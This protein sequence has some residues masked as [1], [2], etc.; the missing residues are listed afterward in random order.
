MKRCRK[1]KNPDSL[2][3]AAIQFML[4]HLQ[5][6][7]SCSQNNNTLL[8][9]IERRCHLGC[10]KDLG[11][12]SFNIGTSMDVLFAQNLLTYNEV[13]DIIVADS[14]TKKKLLDDKLATLSTSKHL[15]YLCTIS[16]CFVYSPASANSDQSSHQEDTVPSLNQTLN[17]SEQIYSRTWAQMLRYCNRVVTQLHPPTVQKFCNYN[18]VEIWLVV[19]G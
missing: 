9:Q 5:E 11:L 18:Y 8:C 4:E 2:K 1:E 7:A 14:Q 6:S 19:W 15:L 12:S 13:V 10:F 17:E 3:P 16:W